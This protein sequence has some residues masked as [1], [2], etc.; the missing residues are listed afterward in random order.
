MNIGA[1]LSRHARYRPDHLALVAGGQRLTYRELNAIVNRLA[2]ALLANGV[3]KG[4][5][6]ATLLPNCLELMTPTGP[7]PRP[8]SSSSHEHAAAGKGAGEPAAGFRIPSSYLLTRPS[9]RPWSRIR[10]ELPAM[11]ADRFVLVGCKGNAPPGFRAYDDFTAEAAEDNPPDP[12]LTGAD[13]Y[14]IMYS[15]GTTGAPKGIVHTHHVRAMYCTLF[16]S[17]WRMTPESVVLHAGALVFNGA[18]LDLIPG[19]I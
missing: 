4:D 17:A 18:M 19:C 15:S 14:N 11:R 5:K 13:M 10:G 7:R 9:P 12:G 8:A 1:L 3:T 16:A 6:I 2:N